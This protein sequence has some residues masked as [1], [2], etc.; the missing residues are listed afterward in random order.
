MALSLD[1]FAMR[2]LLCRVAQRY[3]PIAFSAY[4]DSPTAL[5]AA[6]M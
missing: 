6:A 4:S 5:R 3:I 2:L 1:T